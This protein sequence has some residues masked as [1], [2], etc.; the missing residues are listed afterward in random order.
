M[1]VG[2]FGHNDARLT[3]EEI[4]TLKNMIMNIITT[5]DNVEFFLGGY[6][7]YDYT[8]AK[9]LKNIKSELDNF[10]SFFI[11]PYQ[12][13]VYL[14]NKF[15]KDL[16]DGCIY[17]PIENTPKRYA[18]LKRNYWIIDNCDYLIFYFTHT[19]GGTAKALE[20]A[21]RKKVKF[22]NLAKI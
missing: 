18:I 14:K 19:F 11:S 22:I 8:C 13:Q 21:K 9:I 2:F 12:N 4:K 7:T 6:G 20:Y 15:N 1:K 5:N 10:K 3:V 16:Y 17:P